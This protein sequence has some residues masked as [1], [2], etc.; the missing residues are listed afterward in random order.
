MAAPAKKRVDLHSLPRFG[1]GWT[2][3]Y[4]EHSK[5]DRDGGVL[6]IHDAKGVVGVPAAALCV[7]MLGPG[8]N[9]SHAAITLAVD[10]GMSV[11]WI[12]EQGVRFYASGQGETTS[13]A[14]LERQAT[15]W[16]AET[17]RMEVVLRLYR[18]RFKEPTNPTYTLQQL[19][20]LEGARVRDAYAKAAVDHGIS[21][22]GRN[23][24]QA[25]W[26]AADPVNRALSAANACLYGL[27]HAAIVSTGFSPA[28]GFI[29]TG[30]AH[31]FVYDIADL[32]KLEV[33]VPLAFSTARQG[34]DG[35][36]SRVRKAC[37][38]AFY[39]SALIGRIVPDIQRAL[40]LTPETA[41]LLVHGVDDERITGI[42][43]PAGVIEGGQNHGNGQ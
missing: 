18:M 26:S 21:W 39:Q 30:R 2:F 14:N 23:Y 34:L 24:K 37:R 1:D 9:I 19:R 11:V 20:G 5:I 3:L 6:A 31:S 36:E 28:L 12:G 38:D 29:H 33:C 10:H 25:A 43:G 4:I 32:Y 35:L 41:R 13:S 8:V 17:T 40:G 22:S 27:C 15:A 42:W 16:A 7:L